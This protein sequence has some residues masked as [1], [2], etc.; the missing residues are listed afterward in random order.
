MQIDV[1]A[2]SSLGNAY[3]VSDGATSILLDA[4]IP[5]KELQVKSIAANIY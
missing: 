4:G 1:L 5:Y 2:S 3:I